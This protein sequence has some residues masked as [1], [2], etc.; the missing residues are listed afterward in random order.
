M[1]NVM[2]IL[3]GLLSLGLLASSDMNKERVFSIDTSQTK[4]K[5]LGRKVT[6]AHWGYVRVKQGEL[7]FRGSDLVGG[8]FVMDMTSIDVGDIKKPENNKN[9]VDHLRSDDF[10]AVNTY[11]TA[12]LKIKNARIGKGGAF[13]ISADLTVK[14]ITKPV[15]FQAMLDPFENGVKGLAKI[16]FNR[17][18]YGV[19]Y[20]S[21]S[22]FKNLGDRVIH[23]DVEI[24]V[25][26]VATMKHR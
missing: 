3:A 9:L 21:S 16:K 1:K 5:W 15:F 20:K 4:V 26:L 19:K 23:D 13:D 2:A 25:S 24:D 17:T 8:N 18:Q 14:G 11:K 7:K 12:T 6:G 22:F 10:F